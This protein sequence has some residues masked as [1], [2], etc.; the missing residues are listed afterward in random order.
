M[1]KRAKKLTDGQLLFRTIMKSHAGDHLRTQH[2]RT[3]RRFCLKLEE[4]KIPSEPR[5]K[6]RYNAAFAEF[7]ANEEVYYGEDIPG[8][9]WALAE[10]C[11][12][13]SKPVEYMEFLSIT[14]RTETFIESMGF[15]AKR[16][17]FSIGMLRPISE[18]ESEGADVILRLLKDGSDYA[19]HCLA[20]ILVEGR[21]FSA[22]SMYVYW[23]IAN[24]TGDVKQCRRLCEETDRRIMLSGRDKKLLSLGR[25]G[26]ASLNLPGLVYHNR[27]LFRITKTFDGGNFLIRV[28]A[29]SERIPHDGFAAYH[30]DTESGTI[31]IVLKQDSEFVLQHELQHGFDYLWDGNV[32]HDLGVGS[33]KRAFLASLAFMQSEDGFGDMLYMFR[34]M[35]AKLVMATLF[36]EKVTDIHAKALK[37]IGDAVGY[38]PLAENQ[39]ISFQKAKARA[40]ELLN[41]EY[42]K[43][44]GLT[45]DEIVEPF[46]K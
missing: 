39:N 29:E 35:E 27:K 6:E 30:E 21:E 20:N 42:R 24:L 17:G 34:Y 31:P 44:T 43:L 7:L 15:L 11:E 10:L 8:Y 19:L 1:A 28:L 33:E 5:A 12:K 16:E 36:G 32:C 25:H 14:K 13:S 37:I 40:M 22:A 4:L 3:R 46:R 38:V 9:I 2:H 23:A 26:F 45:Y 41:E 18:E